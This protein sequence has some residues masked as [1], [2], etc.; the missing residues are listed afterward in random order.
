MPVV[1]E[2]IENTNFKNSNVNNENYLQAL[3][4]QNQRA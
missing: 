2:F 1:I 4:S 3:H